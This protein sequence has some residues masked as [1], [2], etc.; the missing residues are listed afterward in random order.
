MTPLSIVRR[1]FSWH[2]R[3]FGERR[4]ADDDPL[5]GYNEP[6]GNPEFEL[7]TGDS[8]DGDGEGKGEIVQGAC[9]VV[10][11]FTFKHHIVVGVSTVEELMITS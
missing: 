5:D 3:P 6:G 10:V 8:A 4:E 7:G 9:D 2:K 1:N 11:F